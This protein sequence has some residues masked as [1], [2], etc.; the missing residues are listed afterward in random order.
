MAD[1]TPS[2]VLYP[3]SYVVISIKRY[4]DLTEED[5]E[6]NYIQSNPKN[7]PDGAYLYRGMLSELHFPNTETI[8]KNAFKMCARIEEADIHNVRSIGSGAFNGCMS[9]KS[10]NVPLLKVVQLGT[11]QSCSSLTEVNV[12]QVTEIKANGF[13]DC[14]SLVEIKLPK[15]TSI[16]DYAFRGCSSLVNFDAPNLTS[17]GTGA[18][19]GCSSMTEIFFINVEEI[20]TAAFAGCENL[21]TIQLPFVQE[22]QGAS[23]FSGCE[24]LEY[25]NLQS[26][27][28]A[29]LPENSLVGLENLHWLN[30]QTAVSSGTMNDFLQTCG[31]NA[32]MCSV[33]CSDK[34][35]FYDN[36]EASDFKQ[37][38]LFTYVEEDQDHDGFRESCIVSI[39]NQNVEGKLEN[40]KLLQPDLIEC[41]AEGIKSGAFQGQTNLKSIF[42]PSLFTKI[43]SNAFN[44]CTNLERA[45]FPTK[46][47]SANPAAEIASSAFKN[48][49]KLMY[50]GV[51]SG[52]VDDVMD[53][54]EA[55]NNW[56]LSNGCSIVC[57]NG[58]IKIGSNGK[59]AIV[60]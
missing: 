15:V 12:P 32:P 54:L 44:G 60:T 7:I 9:L 36:K 22:L 37:E 42:M 16:G 49:P 39:K 3:E 52:E 51:T 53:S 35:K 21:K 48:C 38:D 23:I 55:K 18:F 31:L 6:G 14:S 30:L 1:D 41:A 56:G 17:V 25:L 45:E 46:W 8:G 4:Y 47:I 43:E 26:V 40:G 20:G 5:S 24:N 10:L 11:F 34:V 2:D 19:Y 13:Q 33:I 50:V 58:M 59:A 29:G 28:S 27:T 57:K